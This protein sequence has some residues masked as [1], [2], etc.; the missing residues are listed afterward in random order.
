MR[1]K[2]K[3]GK[4]R[5]RRVQ[6]R[7]DARERRT[8]V[9][10]VTHFASQSIL[11]PHAREC[12]VVQRARGIGVIFTVSLRALSSMLSSRACFVSIIQVFVSESSLISTSASCPSVTGSVALGTD[13]ASTGTH[14][15][16]PEFPEAD[17][18]F[19]IRRRTPESAVGSCASMSAG[20]ISS[21]AIVSSMHGLTGCDV[22]LPCC[23]SNELR[24]NRD[25]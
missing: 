14:G 13:A 1:R 2:R 8:I 15:A 5:S 25:T 12:C 4:I 3:G 11:E 10:K 17:A 7:H 20:H 16:A 24:H 23:F 21:P 6:M 18:P 9:S 22:R 19:S